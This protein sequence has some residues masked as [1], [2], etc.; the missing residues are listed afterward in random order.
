LTR[1]NARQAQMSGTI[2]PPHVVGWD[3]GE[4]PTFLRP[5]CPSF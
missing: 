2:L 1:S 5:L 3:S 4:K